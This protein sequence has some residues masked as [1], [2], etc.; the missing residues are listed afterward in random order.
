MLSIDEYKDLVREERKTSFDMPYDLVYGAFEHL[1]F[2]LQDEIFFMENAS[3]VVNDLRTECW[4]RFQIQEKEFT[5]KMLSKLIN[6]K[7]IESM[8]SIDAITYFVENFPTHIYNLNLSNTQS[9]RS[10]A[11]KEFETIIE[12]LLIG[13]KI[14]MDA[15]GNIGKKHLVT[16]DW[17]SLLI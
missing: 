14:P 15:Q 9:R 3:R 11:G 13:A 17:E 6:R 10:R 1:K 4:K 16:K 5:S 8:S 7:T 2:H 12:L